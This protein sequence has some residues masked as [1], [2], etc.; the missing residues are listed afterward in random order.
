VLVPGALEPLARGSRVARHPFARRIQEAEA[1]LAVGVALLRR[2]AEVLRGLVV[3][4]GLVEDVG[5]QALC[6]RV[7]RVGG[8]LERSHGRYHVA[9]EVG[10][11][12]DAVVV[13]RRRPGGFNE[14]KTNGNQSCQGRLP[15]SPVFHA[16][17]KRSNSSSLR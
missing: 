7:A 1:V 15:K 2:A 10:L 5:V 9:R 3:V 13:L 4:L 8:A 12:P 6:R 16:T 17:P 14:S 11:A